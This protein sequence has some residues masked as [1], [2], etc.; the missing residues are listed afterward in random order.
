MIF[1]FLLLGLACLQSF[2]M[3]LYEMRPEKCCYSYQKSQIPVKFI[4][5]YEETE[6]RCAQP[7]VIFLLKNGY[8]MCANPED[9]WVKK[10]KKTIDQREFKNLS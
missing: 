10:H 7:G 5:A 8:Q 3:A 2:T 4:T 1:P 9:G 6:L